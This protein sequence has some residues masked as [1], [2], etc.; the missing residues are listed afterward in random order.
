MAHPDDEIIFGFPVIKE[1]NKIIICSSDLNNPERAWCGDRKTAFEE[2]C[3]YLGVK[4]VCLDYNSE[5]YRLPTRD[6]TLKKMANE[7]LDIV[8]DDIFTHNPWGEYG[9]LDHILIH[10]ILKHKNPCYSDIAID[11]N[12]LPIH[13]TGEF[14]REVENDLDLYNKIKSIYDK[15]GCWTW[16]QPPILKAKLCK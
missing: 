16:S 13:K 14:V 5:F 3:E 2:V 15:Y 10:N 1:V 6:E 11:L 8:G 12:W 7:I 9:H 4:M